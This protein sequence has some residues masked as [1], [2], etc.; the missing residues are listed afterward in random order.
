MFF[1]IGRFIATEMSSGSLKNLIRGE[2]NGPLFLDY[3]KIFRQITSGLA[4]LHEKKI[5]HRHLKPANI[6]ISCPDGSTVSPVIKLANFG[7]TRKVQTEGPISLWKIAGSKSWLGPEV[8]Q[9]T[10][11]KVEMDLF[12]LGCVMAFSLSG[13]KHPYGPVKEQRI[14]NIWTKQEIVITVHDLKPVGGASAEEMLSLLNSLMNANTDARPSASEV[15]SH[16]A[17]RKDQVNV[18]VSPVP[19]PQGKFLFSIFILSFATICPLYKLTDQSPVVSP[20]QVK[21]ENQGD[22][23]TIDSPLTKKAKPSGC[24]F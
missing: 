16:V 21:R 19:I 24:Y 18:A 15:L 8:Y 9:A 14:L 1:F 12:S 10:A 5:V 23:I 6:L 22:D 4:H 2:Y 3:Q 17:L 11:F 7:I 13:G 20:K